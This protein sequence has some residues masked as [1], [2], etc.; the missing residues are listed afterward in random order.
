MIPAIVL[1]T[2]THCIP[3]ACRGRV[4][5]SMNAATELFRSRVAKSGL[6]V[7]RSITRR[8]LGGKEGAGRGVSLGRPVL[9]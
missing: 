9:V 5:P 4:G 2:D 6:G 8:H 7:R 1:K 3:R